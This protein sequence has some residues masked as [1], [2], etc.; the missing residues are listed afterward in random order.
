MD[1]SSKI[2]TDRT[3]LRQTLSDTLF[4]VLIIGGGI[5][6]A[7]LA[8]QA[9]ATGL[10][11]ALLERDDYASA[12]SSRS[13]KMAHG[14]L[15]YLEMGDF[16]QVFE[17]IK[18]REN[19]FAQY[20]H[21]VKPHRF[22][23][24]I[25]AG[26][27]F[28]KLKL[29]IG[30]TLYDLMVKN[31][32]RKHRWIPRSK[33]NFEGF[34]ADRT[35]LAGCFSYT[36]GILS[37]CRLVLES[38][39]KARLHG[40]HCLNYAEVLSV[41]DPVAGVISVHCKD[42][43]AGKEFKSK[44]RLVVNCAGPWAPF[45]AH[46]SLQTGRWKARYSQ[47][48]HL[49]F[50]KAWNGPALFLPMEG[51]ARYYFVWPHFSG[52]MVGTTEREVDTLER[53]PQPEPGEIE[54]I[55]T[56]LK[57]DLP[58]S[59]LDENALHYAFAGV[60]TLPLRESAKET[61]RLSRKHIWTHQNGLLTLL[62]GKLTTADWTASEGLQQICS[63]L[64]RSTPVSDTVD[65]QSSTVTRTDFE[66][67]VKDFGLTEAQLERVWTRY[68]AQA[69]RVVASPED[70]QPLGTFAVVGELRYALEVEQATS[71]EDIMRRR[72]ELEYMPGC[73]KSALPQVIETL[74]Q[75]SNP[76]RV[77]TELN[78]YQKRLGT[79]FARMGKEN[80][81]TVVEAE[82]SAGTPDLGQ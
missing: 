20:P 62:G 76:E 64:G 39:H 35:D 42:T 46:S 16:Q 67:Q 77:A 51:K 80:P 34:S 44:A 55:L 23:I 27:W 1:E 5:H 48:T 63:L 74:R 61:G 30:L 8:R 82:L 41:S 57:K 81:I 78:G 66:T 3:Q 26:A 60:R 12:T 59:G 22:L 72:L 13:S 15:R 54:E 52:T 6:G 7:A 43:C 17:G 33:L 25:P 36:D 31:P 38:I 28:Q 56:R 45:I 11:V 71:L 32:E 9:A 49:L 68:G 40:A 37:D 53:D 69:V 58:D 24:P 10:T 75:T 19:L 79:L 14:G 65:V 47:G 50:S 2:S 29:T 73:G 70:A 4:D 18:A 21:L